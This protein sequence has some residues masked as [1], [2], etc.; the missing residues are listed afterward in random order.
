[1]L[2]NAE[3]LRATKAATTGRYSSLICLQGAPDI[4]DVSVAS[5]LRQRLLPKRHKSILL[6]LFRSL[7][8]SERP[9]I[10]PTASR[11]C[12]A[13]IRGNDGFRRQ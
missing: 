7:R 6:L 2:R 13:A 4:H 12:A 9:I 3:Q 11:R 10:A 8:C 1:M 5:D